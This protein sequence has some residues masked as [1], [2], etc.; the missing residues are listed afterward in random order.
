MTKTNSGLIEYAKAQVGKPYWYGCFGQ[1][2][3]KD[4]LISKRKQYPTQYTA[5]DFDDQMGVKVHDCSGLI[6]GYLWCNSPDDDQ[7]KYNSKQDLGAKAMYSKASKHGKIST[8]DK[9]N[10]RLVFKGK[11]EKSIN[12]VGI[13]CDGYVYEAKGHKYGVVKTKFNAGSWTFW[14][15]HP[16]IT[17]DTSKA[18][19]ATKAA[20]KP[21][22]LTVKRYTVTA[23]SGL[24]IR[25][26]AG[27]NYKILG[28]MPKGSTFKVTNTANGWAYG[29]Y[30]GITGYASMIWLDIWNQ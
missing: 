24:R 6:K 23:K 4:L 10:G 1:K 28:V 5:S 22:K 29:T 26:G 13:Y 8:F 27:T 21:T 12:H 14:G 18:T 15:Q 19:T 7:P 9:V 30:A 11:S 3:G 25:A 17:D 16:D 2:S 20:T